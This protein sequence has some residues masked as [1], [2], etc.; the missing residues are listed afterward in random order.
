MEADVAYCAL[1]GDRKVR[2]ANDALVCFRC[3][4]DAVMDEARSRG[5]RANR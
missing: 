2:D 4:I 5:G 3:L 1:H